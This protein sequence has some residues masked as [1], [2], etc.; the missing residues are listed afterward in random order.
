MAV[1]DLV[2]DSLLNDSLRVI[3][4]SVTIPGDGGT[5]GYV[6]T[7]VR[8]EGGA[9][10]V[11]SYV[12]EDMGHVWSGPSGEGLFTDHA[13]PDVSAIVWDFA[14]RHARR[15]VSEHLSPSRHVG[16]PSPASNRSQR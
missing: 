3:E 8:V 1:G 2:D 15:P 10:L 7:T 11:E 4:E 9:S 6:H 16:P 5:H 14:R 12:V 13:G